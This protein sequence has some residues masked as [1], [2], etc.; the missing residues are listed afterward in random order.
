[1][2]EEFDPAALTVGDVDVM[3]RQALGSRYFLG[4]LLGA[5]R[6][7]R[8]E[9]WRKTEQY[10]AL[11]RWCYH[12]LRARFNEDTWG[13]FKYNLAMKLGRLADEVQQVRIDEALET[14]SKDPP[15]FPPAAPTDGR[16]T[17]PTGTLRTPP[18]RRGEPITDA[19]EKVYKKIIAEAD[20]L[21][22]PPAETGA[23]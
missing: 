8:Y 12:Y 15:P 22:L 23:R 3:M 1:M 6:W 2:S 5:N 11:C 13:D 9:L 21:D 10:Q 19:E 4:D 7:A 14:L 16:M 20:R 18:R 17:T